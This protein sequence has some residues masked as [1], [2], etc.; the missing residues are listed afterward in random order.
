MP[1]CP[2]Q[3]G[4]ASRYA[5]WPCVARRSGGFRLREE[6]LRALAECQRQFAAALRR[7][8]S[9]AADATATHGLRRGHYRD[10]ALR[11]LAL[12]GQM[13][14]NLGKNRRVVA[15]R[16]QGKARLR[17]RVGAPSRSGARRAPPSS[18][19]DLAPPRPRALRRGMREACCGHKSL[20]GVY[21]HVIVS[22]GAPRARSADSGRPGSQPGCRAATGRT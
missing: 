14:R 17:C 20:P 12:R 1:T 11:F 6:Y 8:E 22:V 4:A 18:E 3:D 10:R 15:P 21:R 13:S 16:R 5:P 7:K 9:D 19:P 2:W